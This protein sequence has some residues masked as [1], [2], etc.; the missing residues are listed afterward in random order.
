MPSHLP[1][2][3]LTDA[4]RALLGFGLGCLILSGLNPWAA[5]T[6]IPDFYNP[7]YAV[8]FMWP[9][10]F[11]T[12][13]TYLVVGGGLLFAFVF[14]HR[15]WVALAWFAANTFLWLLAAGGIDMFVVGGGLL[16]LLAGDRYFEKRRGLFLRVLAYGL[17]MVKPQGTVFIVGLYVLM[18]QDWKGLLI[19]CVVYGLAFLPL[20][21]AWLDVILHNPPMAQTQATHTLAAHYGIWVAA[22]IAIGVVLKRRWRYWQ[23]GGAL[24]G[25]LMPYGM[26]GVPIFLTL[27]A[28]EPLAAIPIV[29]IWSACLAAL[30]W[31]TPPPGVDFYTFLS[32]RMAIYHLSMLGLALALAI[33]SPSA[34][35]AD[36]IA[37]ADWIKSR[38]PHAPQKG[39]IP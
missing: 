37:V 4:S 22:L 31:V 18:R 29:V 15:T 8:L 33:L 32:P 10:V 11:L 20:Y 13:K 35:G 26:P 36:T 27:T 5:A 9:M 14:Y 34:A 1:K 24:A 38:W 21:P 16:L 30:T 17:L 7:P 12:A 28:V 23:I 2:I 19:C 6:R 3:P 39:L 25:I